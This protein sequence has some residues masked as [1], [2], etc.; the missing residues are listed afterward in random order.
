MDKE[1]VVPPIRKRVSTW[2]IVAIILGSLV[3]LLLVFCIWLSGVG[4]R[5]WAAMEVRVREMLAEA[6]ARDSARPALRGTA[7]PGSAWLDYELAIQEAV[8]FKGSV[9]AL[10]EYVSRGP[11]ADRAKVEAVLRDHPAALEHLRRGAARSHGQYP[12]KWEDGFSQ[13]IPGLLSSQNLANLAACRSRFLVEEGKPREAAELLLDTCLFAHDLGSNGVLI[14]EMIAVAIYSISF[15]ELRD[16]ILSGRLSPEDLAE[17]GRELELL[18]RFFLRNDQTMMNEAMSVGLGF[19]RMSETGNEEEI[20]GPGAGGG[21][22]FALASHLVLADAFFTHLELM[23]RGG[24]SDDRPWAEVD[25]IG[26]EIQ[27]DMEHLKNPISKMMVPGLLGC[28]RTVRERRA[29]LR[30]LRIAAHYRATGEVLEL[31]DPFGGKLLTSKAG[32]RLKL[33][34]VGRD[35]ADDG[36]TGEWKPRAGKDIVLETD[37]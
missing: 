20:L 32:D 30:L 16:L 34:S 12:Y 27:D 35:G 23:K 6:R 26:R 36:G 24:G 22:K 10:G 21:L 1:P 2:K 17:V 25:R 28:S 18:D 7:V 13:P 29:Q 9:S 15:D 4:R 33:W 19:I 37:R 5:R 11:K 14:A 3:L 31:D 8:K